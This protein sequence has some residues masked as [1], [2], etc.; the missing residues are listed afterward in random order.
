MYSVYFKKDFTTR[1]ASACAARAIPS[2]DIGHSRFDILRFAV[3]PGCQSDQA[4][5]QETVLFWRSFM[6]GI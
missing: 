1:G 6:R 2:F 4:N 3:Y 5:H